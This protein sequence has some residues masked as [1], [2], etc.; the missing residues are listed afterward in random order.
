M[1]N[2]SRAKSLSA[3]AAVNLGDGLLISSRANR[4]AAMI[5]AAMNRVA[6]SNLPRLT[7]F[8]ERKTERHNV[9]CGMCHC[10]T[11]QHRPKPDWRFTRHPVFS[12]CPCRRCVGA[13]CVDRDPGESTTVVETIKLRCR[14]DSGHPSAHASRQ[15]LRNRR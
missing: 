3:I 14:A 13:G 6:G 11:A 10:R 1:L 7:R 5:D 12:H 8:L 2:S 9:D 4:T 15:S